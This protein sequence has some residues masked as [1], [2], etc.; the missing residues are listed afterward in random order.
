MF[1]FWKSGRTGR[2]HTGTAAEENASLPSSSIPLSTQQHTAT[3]RELVR[4]VLRDTL[5]LNGIPT[6]WVGCEIL[7]R[8]RRGD[9]GALLIQLLIHHWHEGLLRYAPLLQQQLLQGLQR[10]DPA[11]DHSR[12]TVSWKFSPACRAPHNEMPPP[13]F[14]TGQVAQFELPAADYPQTGDGLAPRQAGQ[15]R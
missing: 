13:S 4:V 10:F 3:H 11:S 1:G 7:T 6:D 14:W 9:E 12:H 8:S 5:R 15:R 2:K